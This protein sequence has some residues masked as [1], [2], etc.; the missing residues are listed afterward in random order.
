M[1]RKIVKGFLWRL[2]FDV[3]RRQEVQSTSN[4]NTRSY[5]DGVWAKETLE[6]R[7]YAALHRKICALVPHAS[8]VLDVGCGNGRL[9]RRLQDENR[10]RA[11]GLDLSEIFL[12]QLKRFNISTVQAQLPA[13]PFQR[14]T[15]DAV[16]C[17]E[18]LEHLDE[19]AAVV[20]E[21]HRITKPGGLIL[22][23]V[24]DGAIWGAGG[25]HVQ[26]F[27]AADCHELMRP[28]VTNLNIFALTDHGFPHLLCWGD[29]ASAPPTYHSQWYEAANTRISKRIA[30]TEERLSSL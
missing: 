12:P 22:F 14:S 20:H 9:L 27:T 19:P 28:Y 3:R 30:D 10:C 26:C 6:A 13:V 11:F 8:W 17:C 7:E 24:P 2:G 5:W 18:T 25:E 21:L 29:K 16:V 4:I 23:S 15:F 1:I